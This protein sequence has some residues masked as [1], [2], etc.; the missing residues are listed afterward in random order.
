M[1]TNSSWQQ[2]VSTSTC[3]LYIHIYSSIPFHVNCPHNHCGNILTNLLMAP[4]P[5]RPWLTGPASE[6]EH[7]PAR[8]KPTSVPSIF[9]DS[10]SS[11]R[12]DRHVDQ[13]YRHR[14]TTLA[15]GL[16]P[17]PSPDSN[18]SYSFNPSILPG[19][20]SFPG[21]LDPDLLSPRHI[22][23]PPND[24]AE[25]NQGYLTS[26]PGLS[27]SGMQMLALDSGSDMDPDS[28]IGGKLMIENPRNHIYQ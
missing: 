8:R 16:A 21:T 12:G 25:V 14:S 27:P 28:Q 15:I 19:S 22:H 6:H 1:P 26:S 5:K 23:R 9:I 3:E 18:I 10:Q 7:P 2:Y 11:G 20:P 17:S 4:P 13:D 24:T